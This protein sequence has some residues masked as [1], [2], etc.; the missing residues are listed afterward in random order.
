MNWLL[1]S[2]EDFNLYVFCC[3]CGEFKDLV[4]SLIIKVEPLSYIDL[5]S[6]LLIHEFLHKNSLQSLDANA[7]HSFPINFKD[8]C[9]VLTVII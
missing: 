1:L 8:C 7:S 2:L 3:L 6:H 4:T 5:Y 9:K